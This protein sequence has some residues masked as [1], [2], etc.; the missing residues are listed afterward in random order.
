M[1]RRLAIG[2]GILVLLGVT[3]AL[4]LKVK[5]SPPAE[6]VP[7]GVAG[8][9]V[10]LPQVTVIN[11]GRDRAAGR[12]VVLSGDRIVSVGG[13][14]EV[15]EVLA[16]YRGH[17]VLPGLID[18]HSHLPPSTPLRLTEYISLLN[19]AYG[20]TTLREP[21]DLSGTAVDAAREGMAKGEFPGPRIF[22]C[23]P[24]ITGGER[25]WVNSIVV[26]TPEEARQA[27]GEVAAAGHQCVKS[28]EDLTVEQIRA[29]VAEARERGLPVLSH[30]PYQLGY[31][32]AL[33]P[34][35]EHLLGI[36][37]PS[38]LDRDHMV[39]RLAQWGAVDDARL[40]RIV[41]VTLEHG[42]ENT[43]TLVLHHRLLR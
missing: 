18:M 25:R 13:A 1:K 29:L 4:F 2:C 17:Y 21:G 11:P 28:Y 7:L 15:G 26:S 34:G 42:I 3:G 36:P 37:P 12:T 16:N 8:Q 6:V 32:E 30:V 40:D 39:N 19:L 22:S 27:V 20:I 35:V 38:T 14:P 23:G 43:P 9:S 10:V 24:F 33:L 31:D 41:E 5:F